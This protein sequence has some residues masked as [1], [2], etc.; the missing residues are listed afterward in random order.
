MTPIQPS[1]LARGLAAL[2]LL[3]ASL[4][5]AETYRMD[6]IVFADRQAAGEAPSLSALPDLSGALMLDNS[7]ALSAAG[8]TVLPDAQFGL[9]TEWQR[10]RNSKRFTP[11]MKI[12][13]TQ[14][15]PAGRGP[16]L[17]V[18][19]G[20]EGAMLDG[21]VAMRLVDRYLTLDADLAYDTGTGIYRLDQR[22]KMRRDELHHLDGA[23]LGIIT[24]V[25]KAG[26]AVVG[27]SP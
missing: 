25:S 17:R 7:A 2:L 8:I 22:R 19:T 26:T 12:S 18:R 21:R 13:W 24:K 6:V 20:S 1:T 15:D 5:R 23:R 14:R 9:Q 16:A 27:G 11:L 10:L 4:A 3:G